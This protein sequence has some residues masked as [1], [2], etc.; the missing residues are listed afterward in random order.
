MQQMIIQLNLME[1]SPILEQ[2]HSSIQ[3]NL[4]QKYGLRLVIPRQWF[5][6]Q[7]KTTMTNGDTI[8]MLIL[9]SVLILQ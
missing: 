3:P 1:L 2:M 8:S 6:S 5:S 4:L 7:I 9:A